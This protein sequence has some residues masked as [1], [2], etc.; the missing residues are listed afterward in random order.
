MAALRDHAARL[1][2][3]DWLR[4]PTDWTSL[5]TL[6]DDRAQ[7][8]TEVAVYRGHTRIHFRVYEGEELMAFWSRLIEEI[9]E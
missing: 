7:P 1:A 4:R 6:Y 9:T 8:Y 2:F 5:A 3:P